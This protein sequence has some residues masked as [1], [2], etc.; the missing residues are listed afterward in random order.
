MHN[1]FIQ[2]LADGHVLWIVNGAAIR[3]PRFDFLCWFH[4]L[5][6]GVGWLCPVTK[7]FLRSPQAVFH[8]VVL[9]CVPNSFFGYLFPHILTII[10][11]WKSLQ[12][13]EVNAHYGFYVGFPD[14]QWTSAPSYVC[15][16]SALHLKSA[17]PHPL[18]TSNRT[19][20][21]V[22]ELECWDIL[23]ISP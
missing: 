22:A 4:L 8:K 17:C 9:I 7:L 11:G 5:F 23:N 2:R 20:S 15:G 21:F 19:A 13:D 1:A 10:F 3:V 6:P 14:R 18:P 12:Q 16:L